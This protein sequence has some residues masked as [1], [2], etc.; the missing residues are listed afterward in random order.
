MIIQ[1]IKEEKKVMKEK[2]N[3]TDL[4]HENLNND[5]EMNT[6]SEKKDLLNLHDEL[7]KENN[8]LASNFECKSC[9]KTFVDKI[10][11]GNHI[12]RCIKKKCI[13][14]KDYLTQYAANLQIQVS[15]QII[16]LT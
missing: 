14:Q 7:S 12:S 1:T 10:I 9:G 4:E 5:S 11:L 2:L 16:N 15:H 8:E 13:D 3:T 6:Y